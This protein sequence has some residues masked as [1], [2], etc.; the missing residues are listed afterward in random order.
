[1]QQLRT[2]QET[3]PKNQISS[4]RPI[5]KERKLGRPEHL[6]T[7][8]V[9]CAIRLYAT[10]SETELSRRLNVSRQTIYRKMK[11]IPN[12]TIVQILRELGESDL[13]PYQ[14]SYEGFLTIPEVEQFK[15]TLERRQ[16]SNRYKLERLRT[17][18]HLCTYLKRHPRTLSVEECADLLTML[19]IKQIPCL[20][21]Y[22]AKRVMRSWFQNIL[23]INGETLTSKGIDGSLTYEIGKRSHDRLTQKQRKAFMKKLKASVEKGSLFNAWL[24]LPYFLYYT[25]TRI[26]AT[27]KAR[28]ENIEKHR[29]YWIIT[30][31]DKGRHKNGRKTWRKII[32]GELKEKLGRNL[33]SRGNPESGY[34]FPFSHNEARLLF[35][36][37]YEKAKIPMPKQP[38]HIWRH[39]SAQ[40]FL[41]AT[42]WNY[43]LC[44]QT[45][46]WECS[47]ILKQCY[48]SISETAKERA[49][50]KAMG[51]RVQETRKEFKF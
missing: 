27:L 40:D 28:I 48:G 20:T 35:R 44:A 1:M 30:V 11:L 18:W 47:M 10:T 2:I 38:C 32:I 16:V 34:L 21:L 41:E 24:S 14:M 13:K 23:G 3:K 7:E 51:L 39:T 26:S 19:K 5:G 43:E 31:I 4:E 8:D 50:K 33:A 49:L 9:V 17:L 46:G 12:E 37:T 45:L 25:A 22:D 36:R 15:K 42:A 29:E 6:T